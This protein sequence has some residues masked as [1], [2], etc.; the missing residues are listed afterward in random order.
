M[1][2]PELSLCSHQ[3]QPHEVTR[4]TPHLVTRISMQSPESPPSRHLSVVQNVVTRVTPIQSSFRSLNTVTI[5]IPMQSPESPPRSHQSK[6]H[7]VTR[8]TPMQSAFSSL[9]IVTRVNPMQSPESPCSHFNRSPSRQPF[10]LPCYTTLKVTSPACMASTC[11][12]INPALRKCILICS[13]NCS[14]KTHCKSTTA[15]LRLEC[16][17]SK[18]FALVQFLCGLEFACSA[19]FAFVCCQR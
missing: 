19:H 6:P 5:V 9:N 15:P 10:S 16:P 18:G 3:R 11:R 13:P 8:V 1:L 12:T 2:S 4:V 14:M 7:V 17:P